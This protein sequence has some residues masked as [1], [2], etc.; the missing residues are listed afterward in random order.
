[1]T[2][3]DRVLVV[4][5]LGGAL[6]HYTQELT[7]VLEATG[8]HVDVVHIPEPSSGGGSAAHWVK[9][10]IAA[11]TQAR[12]ARGPVVVTWPVLGYVDVLIITLLLGAR[13]SLVMHDPRPLV[14]ARGYGRVWQRLGGIVA[15]R[16]LLVHSEQ[17]RAAVGDR[18]L[19]E[20]ARLVPHPMLPPSAPDRPDAE[21]P[22]RVLG[23]Y[24]PDRD[25]EAL[26]Q[27]ADAL[28]G[29]ALEVVGRRWPEVRGWSVRPHFVPEEQMD[30]LIAESSVVVVP[31]K[32]FFQSGIAV[33][34]LE[35]GTPFVG[36]AGTS[37]TDLLSANSSLLALDDWAAAVRYAQTEAGN[38]ES[39]KAGARYYQRTCV[40]WNDWI[41]NGR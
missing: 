26:R 14:K 2:H 4:N 16:S 6:A 37:M 10:Y 31:Y 28:P 19:R 12:H 41:D 17:A 36:P 40:A 34:C 18:R 27:I 13:A 30:D 25:L 3:E 21:G 24:K 8:A 1:M 35:V 5:P 20:R 23:Q 29:S 9:S 33:R 39:R 15:R 7:H 38:T 32:R 11:L 22:V